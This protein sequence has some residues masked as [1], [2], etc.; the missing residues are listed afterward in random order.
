MPKKKS[1]PVNVHVETVHSQD[2][3]EDEYVEDFHGELIQIGDNQYLRYREKMTD[4]GHAEV[5]F[6]F[7][8]NK[9]VQLT[10][11]LDHQKLRLVFHPGRRTVAHYQTPYGII[12]LETEVQQLNLLFK[13]DPYAGE[14]VIGYQ[15]WNE[16]TL[17][18]DYKIRLQFS[19]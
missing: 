9:E 15:L 8:N 16:E 2:G 11:K 12:P 6:K 14:V 1:F 7:G 19:V 3:Q 18:G 5:M 13:D 10:R 17:L 4:E